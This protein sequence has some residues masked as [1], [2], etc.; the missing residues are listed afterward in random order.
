[1]VDRSPQ[2]RS[3]SVA[4]YRLGLRKAMKQAFQSTLRKYRESVKGLS[5]QEVAL[6]KEL[7][8]FPDPTRVLRAELKQQ[9]ARKNLL[10]EKEFDGVWVKLQQERGLLHVSRTK[11][12]IRFADPLMAPFLKAWFTGDSVWPQEDPRQMKLF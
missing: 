3:V 4:D 11:D 7:C 5:Q 6:V 12:T 10:S 9:M 2:E 8:V 1:M